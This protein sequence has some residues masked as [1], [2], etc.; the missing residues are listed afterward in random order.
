MLT[1]IFEMNFNFLFSKK[2]GKRYRRYSF[3]ILW[4]RDVMMTKSNC[5]MCTL[6]DCYIYLLFHNLKSVDEKFKSGDEKWQIVNDRYFLCCLDY[7]KETKGN[8]NHSNI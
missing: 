6:V 3:G 1:W 7:A 8:S 4:F 2:A 5:H